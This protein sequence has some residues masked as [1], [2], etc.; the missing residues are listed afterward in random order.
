MSMNESKT[1]IARQITAES[2]GRTLIVN[3]EDKGDTM[4][5]SIARDVEASTFDTMADL[6]RAAYA[7]SIEVS[8]GGT[9]D[10]SKTN[11]LEPLF[12]RI[13]LMISEGELECESEEFALEI[14]AGITAAIMTGYPE[15]HPLRKLGEVAGDLR[16]GARDG[17]S[18]GEILSDE[19]T[20][21]LADTG[22][23]GKPH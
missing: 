2:G 10:G 15:D 7:L 20:D 16:K 19:Q 23:R 9:K 22:I 11:R 12:S 3:I 17:K 4:A 13:G 1:E 6:L 18:V 5:V 14:M 21:L 8:E